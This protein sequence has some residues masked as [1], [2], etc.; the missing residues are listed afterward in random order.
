MPRVVFALEGRAWSAETRA[1]RCGTILAV[2]VFSCTVADADE[3]DKIVKK[4]RSGIALVRESGSR[5]SS[6]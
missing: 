1:S 2:L 3:V 5:G 4:L 6:A